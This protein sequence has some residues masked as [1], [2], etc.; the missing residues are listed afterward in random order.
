M[1]KSKTINA[2]VMAFKLDV[3]N[4]IR[5]KW[6]WLIKENLEYTLVRTIPHLWFIF[7]LLSVKRVEI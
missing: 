4:L 2:S 1:N 7:P 6:M 5:E 3:W